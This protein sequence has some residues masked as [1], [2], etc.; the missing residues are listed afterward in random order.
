MTGVT[1]GGDK[2]NRYSGFSIK[3]KVSFGFASMTLMLIIVGGAGLYG[4]QALGASLDKLAAAMQGNGGIESEVLDI[5]SQSEQLV[6]MIWA[7][8][9]IGVIIAILSSLKISNI[10]V[11]PIQ[12]AIFIAQKIRSGNLNSQI[13]IDSGGETGQLLMSLRD[14]QDQLRESS[15]KNGESEAAN[16]RIQ[17][18]L[19]N[20]SANVMVA[21]AENNIIYLNEAVQK[22]FQ[23][24]ETDIRKGLPGFTA[25]QLIGTNIDKFHKNPAHQQNLLQKLTGRHDAEFVVGGRTMAFSANAIIDNG[26]RLGTVVEWRDRTHE[27]ATESEIEGVIVSAQNGDLS[28]RMNMQGKDGFFL[29]LS[30]GI[31][32][33]I[34]TLSGVFDEIAGV[35]G[36]MSQ[37]NLQRKMTGKHAGTFAEVQ[38]NVNSTI[39]ALLDIVNTI[40]ESTDLIS[41]GSEEISSGN[42]SLSER[43]EQQAASLEETA[44]SMELLTSTVRQNANNAQHANQLADGARE[45]AQGGGEIVGKAVGA[46]TDIN[47]ASSKIA[48]IVSVIDDIAFQTNLLALNASVE[49]ARAGEQGRGFAVV[50]TEV[51]NLAQR[52]ATSAKEI[53]ELIQDSVNKVDVGSKLVN[54]SGEA[55]ENI[56]TSV[57][58]VGDIVAEIATASQ[59][60]ATGID[61]V[62]KTINNLD[63]LT[64]QNAALAEETSAASV[65]MKD[66]AGMMSRQVEFFQ[67]GREVTAKQSLKSKPA[68]VK[69]LPPKPAAAPAAKVTKI[70]KPKDKPKPKP[71]EVKKENVVTQRFD[72][73]DDDWE[74]F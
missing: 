4:I 39:D 31:N 6:L 67:V 36:E 1:S 15:E 26:N 27:V 53:K 34:E 19:D 30:Q 29:N 7:S 55:L 59:E 8:L 43:T 50:A 18:A 48:E 12:Q 56:V 14:L 13:Q 71:P 38:A 44:S 3:Q 20:V 45:T 74:E 24:A 40:R 33:L 62:N 42:N 41:S 72:S 5:A 10:V 46:M 65:S 70:V 9:A 32:Q 73:N 37:G 54:E 21:D 28:Q 11:S 58:K 57:I 60:Q 35:M 61:Q 49:A 68:V 64:Q 69:D 22:M 51:R 47:N 17:Q 25:S 66:R 63:E 23:D 2:M 52:S 16:A